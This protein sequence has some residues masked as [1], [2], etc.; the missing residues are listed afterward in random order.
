MTP[1]V[2]VLA[3]PTAS[4]KT[5]L[6]VRLAEERGAE[7]VG[8]DGLQI[9]RH[10]DIGSGKPSKALLARV[11]HHL[12]DRLD[13]DEP[14]TA[15]RYAEEARRTIREIAGRGRPAIVVGG[16]GFYLRALE[17]PPLAFPS[18]PDVAVDDLARAYARLSEA[19][20]EAAE[21]IHPNDRYRIE[22]AT[23][24]LAAGGRPSDLFRRAAARGPVVRMLWVGIEL[25]RG[26][27]HQRIEARVRGMFAAG[28]E[29]ETA[30]VL[31]RF[32]GARTRLSRAIG[33]R[34]ALA[35]IEGRLAPSAAVEAA[36]V[37]TRRYARRQLT[38]FRREPRIAWAGEAAVFDKARSIME[39]LGV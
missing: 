37:A 22:R 20:P 2:L 3:G 28:L 21:R 35:S 38:W 7:I 8:A 17:H 23:A 34:E 9:F 4:G 30:S 14:L 1:S 5:E 24:V 27:L 32:P 39:N 18:A 36:I 11:P 33:Y 10:L 19:D 13:P 15:A 16:S 29:A 12:I 25:P 6:A 26:E 31:A